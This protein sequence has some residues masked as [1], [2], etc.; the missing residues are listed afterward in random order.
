M[1]VD[2][3]FGQLRRIDFTFQRQRNKHERERFD[4]RCNRGCLPVIRWMGAVPHACDRS[5]VAKVMQVITADFFAAL[6]MEK[7][8]FLQLLI[9][10]TLCNHPSQQ[11]I[12]TTLNC[13][14]EL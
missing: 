5:N 7:R 9:F 11:D 12:G 4:K 6:S 2:R 8:I 14:Y 13:E 10:L 3:P 1:H